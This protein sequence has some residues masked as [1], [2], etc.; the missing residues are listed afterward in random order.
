LLPLLIVCCCEPGLSWV[1][2]QPCLQ[3]HAPPSACEV[4]QRWRQ[5][6]H[7]QHPCKYACQVAHEASLG[8]ER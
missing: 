3:L 1:E 6:P 2:P 5:Q 8:V 7:M 4:G